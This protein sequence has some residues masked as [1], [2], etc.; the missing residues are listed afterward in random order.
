MNKGLLT[1][2]GILIVA[3]VGIFIKS[4]N[5]KKWIYSFNSNPTERAK[6]DASLAKC[7]NCKFVVSSMVR[8]YNSVFENEKLDKQKKDTYLAELDIHIKSFSAAQQEIMDIKQHKRNIPYFEQ[9]LN[10]KYKEV[11][12]DKESSFD[13]RQFMLDLICEE[14]SKLRDAERAERRKEFQENMKEYKTWEANTRRS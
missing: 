4:R 8:K 3:G 6:N 1:G 9:K 11:A 10:E 5:D 13:V 2:L 7:N 14:L 12:E